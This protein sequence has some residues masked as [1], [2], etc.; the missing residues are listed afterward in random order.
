MTNIKKSI[1]FLLIMI[2]SHLNIVEGKEEEG[3][4][5]IN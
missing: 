4:I 3:G 2:L 5:L 1:T